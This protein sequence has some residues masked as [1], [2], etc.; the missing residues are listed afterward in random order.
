MTEY[1]TDRDPGDEFL[2]P[3]TKVPC[4]WCRKVNTTVVVTV[5]DTW[6]VR[7]GCGNI[8]L[9]GAP[10]LDADEAVAQWE[11]TMTRLNHR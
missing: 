7:C 10:C 11:T 3:T 5:N 9:G 2:V 4:A 1:E 8:V 6:R